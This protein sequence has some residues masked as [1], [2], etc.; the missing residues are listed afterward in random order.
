MLVVGDNIVH[1]DPEGTSRA[2]RD[3]PEK[4]EHLVDALVVTCDRVAAGLMED[5]IVGKHLSERIYVAVGEGIVASSSELLVG[6]GHG[7]W[8]P[9]SRSRVLSCGFVGE[10][11]RPR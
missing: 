6:M 3:C 4:A 10:A 8:V 7:L 2:L 5:C 11:I 9:E 1:G